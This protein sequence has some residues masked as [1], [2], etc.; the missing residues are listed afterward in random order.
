[1]KKL[2]IFNRLLYNWHVKLISL[3]IA[4]LL[5]MYVSGLQEQE[6]LITVK[7]EVRNLPERYVVSNNIPDTVNV[8]L[9]GREENFTLLDTSIL[10]AYVDL[11]KKVFNDARFQIQIDR[12]NLP[13]G[14]KIKEINPRTIHLTLERVVRKNVEVVPVIVD[15]PPY[16]FV[17]SNVTVIPESVYVE[18]PASIIEKM[19]SINTDDIYAGNIRE[20]TIIETGLKLED[21]RVRVV[22]VK[23]VLVKISVKEEYVVKKYRIDIFSIENLKEGFAGEVE[24]GEVELLLREP[25]RYEEKKVTEL[26]RLYLDMNGIDSPGEYSVT[27]NYELLDEKVEVININPDNAKVI[28]REVQ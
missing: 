18:G 8:V 22:G 15:N 19:D 17:F 7:F 13:R 27:I 12:K 3:F 16:G 11:E 2:P 23:K 25:R 1:M 24:S 26:V 21:K 4:F 28:V 6:K 14:L 9:K 5:W 20:N 10:T